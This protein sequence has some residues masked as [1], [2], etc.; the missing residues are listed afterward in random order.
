MLIWSVGSVAAVIALL[1]EIS[2]GIGAAGGVVATLM[3]ATVIGL[4]IAAAPLAEG[5]RRPGFADL[6]W[7]PLLALVAVTA[8]CSAAG[9]AGVRGGLRLSRRRRV[10]GAGR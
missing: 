10:D 5:A 8:L 3:S 2:P 7:L 9:W 6:L 4:V 1:A